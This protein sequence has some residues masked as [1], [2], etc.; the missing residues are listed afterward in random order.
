MGKISSPKNAIFGRFRRVQLFGF[1]SS[2]FFSHDDFCLIATKQYLNK[3]KKYTK[4]IKWCL[5]LRKF[6]ACGAL[7]KRKYC[8]C[9]E[10]LEQYLKIYNIFSFCFENLE[11]KLKNINVT[12]GNH[13]CSKSKGKSAPQAKNLGVLT[14]ETRFSIG[15]LSNLTP[16]PEKFSAF[17]EIP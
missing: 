12:G 7:N 6:S 13:I 14:S 8:F 10:N 16:N 11:E 2:D 9:F 5:L 4:L 3:S 1:F 15:F 17:G